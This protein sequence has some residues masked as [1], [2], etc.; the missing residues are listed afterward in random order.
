M[1]RRPRESQGDL[2]LFVTRFYQRG[3]LYVHENESGKYITYVHKKPEES[4]EGSSLSC[5]NRSADR[6]KGARGALGTKYL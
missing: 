3:S 2:F 4:K 5:L 6:K 1:D